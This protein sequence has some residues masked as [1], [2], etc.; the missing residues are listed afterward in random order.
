[1]FSTADVLRRRADSL[2]A[3]RDLLLPKLVTGQVDVSHLD[4]DAVEAA[5][6]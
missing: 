6:A 5:V 3:I 4:L 1:M 2:A